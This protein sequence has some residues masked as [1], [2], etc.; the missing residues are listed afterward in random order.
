MSSLEEVRALR[1]SG[2]APLPISTG[3]TVELLT[4]EL[5][6]CESSLELL[7]GTAGKSFACLAW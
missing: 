5:A 2:D 1:E 7:T 6:R 4:R 3:K